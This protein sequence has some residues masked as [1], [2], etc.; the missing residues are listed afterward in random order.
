MGVLL[1][2]GAMSACTKKET[3]KLVTPTQKQFVSRVRS[4][5]ANV[6]AAYR[7]QVI[8]H[9]K[10]KLRVSQAQGKPAPAVQ[11]DAPEIQARIQELAKGLMLELIRRLQ[12][13]RTEDAFAVLM[14]KGQLKPLRACFSAASCQT[15]ATCTVRHHPKKFL[16][17]IELAD[18]RH[19]SGSPAPRPTGS[20]RP[21]TGVPP[22]P[23]TGAGITP[24][25]SSAGRGAVD[26]DEPLGLSASAQ[27]AQVQAWLRQRHRQL[28]K[29]YVEEGLAANPKLSGRVTATLQVNQRGRIQ[30][31]RVTAS[32]LRHAAT[33]RCLETALRR[34]WL[35][36]WRGPGGSITVALRLRTVDLKQPIQA[37]LRPDLSRTDPLWDLRGGG[38]ALAGRAPSAWIVSGDTLLHVTPTGKTLRQEA[39][40][41]LTPYRSPRRDRPTEVITSRHGHTLVKTDLALLALDRRYQPHVVWQPTKGRQIGAVALLADKHLLVAAEGSLIVLDAQWKEVGRVRLGMGRA[42]KEVHDILVHGDPKGDQALLLDN[43]V[44][45]I[46]LFRIDLR[47]PSKPRILDKIEDR[48]VWAHLRYQ[49]VDAQAK[50][51]GVLVETGGRC[52][53]GQIAL[54]MRSDRPDAAAVPAAPPQ[55]PPQRSGPNIPS[56][57]PLGQGSPSILASPLFYQRLPGRCRDR[58]LF[59]KG[60]PPEDK[61]TGDRFLSGTRKPPHWVTVQDPKEKKIFLGRLITGNKRVSVRRVLDLS[62]EVC[63]SYTVGPGGKRRCRSRRFSLPDKAQIARNDRWIVTSVGPWLIWLQ[64][65]PNGQGRPKSRHEYNWRVSVTSLTL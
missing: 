2:A 58:S 20:P 65:S 52:G 25:P 59:P 7:E 41:D 26:V 46:Y 29:C 51:W 35:W 47:D 49:W 5:G 10:A 23:N 50:R 32:T 48:G 33:E 60:P 18:L 3:K 21:P 24:Q 36:G 15:F 19:G 6:V 9:V 14:T 17:L 38:R 45:P 44:R 34:A 11:L 62:R 22:G 37:A 53:G 54:L 63:S 64:T 28:R 30:S 61:L 1:T 16:P 13:V 43:V 31:A 12:S 42:T 55:K 39:L 56:Y 57:K 40:I 27:E 4:C 8:L